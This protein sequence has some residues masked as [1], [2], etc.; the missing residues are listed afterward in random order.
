MGGWV[1]KP[2]P[3]CHHG[4]MA[5]FLGSHS[6]RWPDTLRGPW[7]LT[8][9]W[10]EVDGRPE[11][12]GLDIRSFRMKD[13]KARPVGPNMSPVTATVLRRLNVGSLIEEARRDAEDIRRYW[14]TAKG[15]PRR[16]KRL[17]AEQARAFD[18]SDGRRMGRPPLYGPDHYERVA[19]V[20][21]AG[22]RQPRQA[23]ARQFGISPSQASKWI[24]KAEDMGFLQRAEGRKS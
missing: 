16:A 13:D 11:C 6:S 19:E 2:L 17:A 10:A 22:G 12:V 3:V 5:K 4:R 8:F 18:E 24:K 7:Q 15:V 9:H 23:V 21:M 14:A 20:Y 1:V